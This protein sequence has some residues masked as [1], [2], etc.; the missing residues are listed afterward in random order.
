VD[1]EFDKLISLQEIDNEIKALHHF[2]DLTPHKLAEIEQKI[3]SAQQIVQK[4]KEKLIQNQKKRRELEGEVA[5][6]K[7]KIA[8]YKRQLNEVK[9][10]KE[11]TALLKEIEEAQKKVDDMEEQIIV[12]LLEADEIEKEIQQAQE[13][14]MKEEARYLKEKEAILQRQ[15]ECQN[16]LKELEK[17]KEELVAVIAQDQL[18]LYNRIAEK[19]S[20]IAISFVT[21][22][23]CSMCHVR[24]R[25]QVLNELYDMKKIYLCENCG[26]ILYLSPERKE[27]KL[28]GEKKTA[29]S[30]RS[31]SK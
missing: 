3:S 8:T 11:Y 28:E 17:R 10:N 9:T 16:K 1:I 5:V 26:R 29:A 22:D 18:A 4:T 19:K 2:L 6:I 30:A 31:S 7:N 25:P 14:F 24:I 15:Q 23:F 27:K 20:G 21:D 13:N 12:A